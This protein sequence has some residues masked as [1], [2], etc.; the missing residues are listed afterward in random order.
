MIQ[1]NAIRP[2]SKKN[3]SANNDGTL[4]VH[5]GLI[6]RL[7]SYWYE[8]DVVDGEALVQWRDDTSQAYPGKGK[9]LFEV[10]LDSII[11]LIPLHAF[12]PWYLLFTIRLITG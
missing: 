2:F 6:L 5:S 7:F 10:I 1:H 4:D 11:A 9:A 8:M 3:E 12:P